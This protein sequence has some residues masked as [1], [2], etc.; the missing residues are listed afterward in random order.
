MTAKVEKKL[1]K[2]NVLPKKLR[3]CLSFWK[4]IS[5]YNTDNQ[6]DKNLFF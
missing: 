3:L 6:N 4:N 1:N 5:F 2:R